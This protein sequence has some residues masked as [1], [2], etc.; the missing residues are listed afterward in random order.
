MGKSLLWGQ[1]GTG[2]VCQAT[3]LM[4]C[5]I[6]PLREREFWVVKMYEKIIKTSVKRNIYPFEL[7]TFQVALSLFGKKKDVYV[8]A[9]VVI[10]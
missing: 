4:Y 10:N 5:K 1:V 6:T 2:H 3:K 9:V 8:D 7:T